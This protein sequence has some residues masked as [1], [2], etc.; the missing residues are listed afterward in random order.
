M[1]VAAFV[2]GCAGF[3]LA[4]VSLGWQVWTWRHQRKFD[5]R[6][7][8]V[9]EYVVVGS[10]KFEITVVIENQGQTMQPRGMNREGSVHRL[11]GIGEWR[12][13]NYGRADTSGGPMTCSHLVSH[14]SRGN[15][16]LMSYCNPEG[17]SFPNLSRWTRV[18]C[19]SR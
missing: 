12:G 4:L 5:V 13:Q 7:S 14:Q 10:G 11:F 19:S 1:G 16:R 9:S 6:A 8:I 3:G 17:M 2:V 18:Q 15:A